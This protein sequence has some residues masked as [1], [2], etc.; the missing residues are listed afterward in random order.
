MSNYPGE[1]DNIPKRIL[2][3][4]QGQPLN[5]L[6]PKCGLTSL[7]SSSVSLSLVTPNTS[8]AL[9]P[10]NNLNKSPK[11]L[12][13]HH[14]RSFYASDS[15]DLD[16]HLQLSFKRPKNLGSRADNDDFADK[17]QEKLSPLAKRCINIADPSVKSSHIITELRETRHQRK[18]KMEEMSNTSLD[19]SNS[20]NETHKVTK[21]ST[22]VQMSQL[23]LGKQY[24]NDL[25]TI[26]RELSEQDQDNIEH[27]YTVEQRQIVSVTEAVLQRLQITIKNILSIAAIWKEVPLSHLTRILDLMAENIVLSKQY[28]DNISDFEMLKRIAHASVFIIFSVFLL[29]RD[30]KE[31]YLERYILEPFTF[32]TEFFEDMKT[33]DPS[34]EMMKTDMQL[35]HHSIQLFPAYIRHQPY[36]DVRLLTKLIYLFTDII[37][38]SNIDISMDPT[39]HHTWEN[40]KAISSDVL[41]SIFDKIPAQRMFIIDEMLANIDKLPTRRLQKKLQKVSND[42]YATHFT[43]TLILMLEHINCYSELAKVGDP[44]RTVLGS[45]RAEQIKQKEE[46]QSF[47]EHINNTLFGRFLEN[48]TQYRHMLENY[49]QDLIGLVVLPTWPLSVGLLT[50]LWKKLFSILSPQSAKPAAVE[51]ICLQLLGSIGAV[52][53][54][55]KS[56]TRPNED[57][58]LIKLCNYPDFIPQ[59][60]ESFER[61]V[62]FTITN[63][64][65]QEVTKYLRSA[66][67]FYLSELQNAISDS[68]EKDDIIS[69]SMD[70][71]FAK[72]D[73]TGSITLE[74]LKLQDITQD[75]YSILHSSELISFYEPFLNLVLS[76]LQKN[77]IKLRSTAIKC[78]SMLASKN[79][80]VLSSPLVKLTIVEQLGN[81]SAASVKDAILDLVS[82]GSSYIMYYKEINVNYDDDS[83]LVRRH[84]LKINEM[85]YDETDDRSIKSFVASRI[86]LKNEDEEDAIIDSSRQALSKRWIFALSDETSVGAKKQT[87]ARNIIKIMSDVILMDGKCNEVF[88]WYLNFYLLNKDLHIDAD[89]KTITENL[90]FLTDELVQIIIEVQSNDSSSKNLMQERHHYLTLLTIF[91]DSVLSFISKDHISGLYP[92]MVSDDKSDLQYYILHVFN[93]TLQKVSNFKPN[94][95]YD[96]ETTLLSRL[97]KMNARELDEAIP[98]AWSVAS[99]KKDKVRIAK[100]CSSCLLHLNPYLAK[101]T[102]EC[103]SFKTDSKLQRLIYLASGFARFCNFDSNI[104]NLTF[105]HDGESLHEYVAKCLLVLSRTNIAHVIRRISIKN[106]TKL[107]GNHPKLF[108]SKHILKLLDEEFEGS[109]LDI[110]LVILESLYDFFMVEEQKSVRQTGIGAS[111][112]SSSKLK[113]KIL[114]YKKSDSINDG[115]CSAL[116]TRFL[117]HILNICR[118]PDFKSSLIGI[119]LMNLILK[120][121]YVNPSHCIPTVIALLSSPEHYIR[122]IAKGTLD[123]L[124]E[125]HETLV[126]NGVSKGIQM[127]I[128]YTK[129]LDAMTYYRND[130]FLQSLQDVIAT[131]KKRSASFFRYLDKIITGLM[132]NVIEVE[133]SSKQLVSILFISSNL[134]NVSFNSQ[135]EFFRLTKTIDFTAE[136]LRDSILDV[137]RETDEARWYLDNLRKAIVIQQVIEKLESYLLAVFGFRNENV[138]SNMAENAELKGKAM[139]MKKN[140]KAQ[141]VQIIAEIISAANQSSIFNDYLKRQQYVD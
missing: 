37:M 122:N 87:M 129:G 127:A 133:S 131:D 94:F 114:K 28:I 83:L 102:K 91:A 120:C 128:E 61:C 90:N 140:I 17:I 68:D 85:I 96:V 116:V 8:L 39:L 14:L 95:L 97:P 38:S 18:R 34:P 111:I 112:S 100:A 134:V 4:L 99:Q 46:V 54:E 55:I 106:L 86:L 42:I 31:I 81:S 82:I 19:L 107:C 59:F 45:I 47:L 88:Q 24:L 92:Y 57:N 141:F 67:F 72:I 66:E 27:W 123:E 69:R 73:M 78:L 70:S 6:V 89:Y 21:V 20:T 1:H 33:S 124:A 15:H 35:L 40:I 44:N 115:I 25:D 105:I 79:E 62:S 76:V 84:I 65:V 126:L 13:D 137:L 41:I 113:K 103:E 136:Q 104:D 60:M 118:L 132:T 98:L 64:P 16:D 7:L 75:Y 135:Y 49:I 12:D 139:P 10:E 26:L 52:I 36:L 51:A 23:T 109:H 43:T 58:N 56:Q 80:S 93:K 119:R 121:N 9:D 3:S 30:S 50:S 2:D 11:K 74:N 22:G 32:L 110:K 108:N 48:T 101:A 53:F 125:K 117:N 29:N 138:H 63:M 71:F 5:H 130:F 77:K